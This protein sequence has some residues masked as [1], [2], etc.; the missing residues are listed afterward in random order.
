MMKISDYFLSSDLALVA[1]LSLW[2]PIDSIDK[3]DPTKSIF[4]FK[5]DPQLDETIQSFW[6]R[7][8]KV[9]PLELI[10]QL[11]IIKTRLYER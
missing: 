3:T 5:R 1:T 9:E 4:Y 6:K 7:Q 11:K 2:F 8:L 10:S